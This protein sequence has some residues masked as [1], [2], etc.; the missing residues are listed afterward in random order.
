MVGSVDGQR[1]W[2]KELKAPMKQFQWSPDGHFMLTLSPQGDL[3][4]YDDQG[5][6][7]VRRNDSYLLYHD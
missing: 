4:L 5:S 7:L 2:V 6:Y 3:F 1:K